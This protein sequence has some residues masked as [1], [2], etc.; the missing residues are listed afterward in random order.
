MAAVLAWPSR[1]YL[2]KRAMYLASNS[3]LNS[4]GPSSGGSIASGSAKV[5]AL[6]TAELVHAREPRSHL[7]DLLTYGLLLV[8][9]TL[10]KA[11]PLACPRP[12][13]TIPSE[14]AVKS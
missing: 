11:P 6:E 1:L 10:Q 4:P 12:R 8:R 2:S 14:V 5:L 9:P 3:A 7:R 13:S